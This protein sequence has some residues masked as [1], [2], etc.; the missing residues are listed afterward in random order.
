MGKRVFW[1]AFGAAAGILVVR[2]ASKTLGKLTP[3]ALAEGAAGLPGVF[4][5]AL[6]G[7]ADEVRTAAAERE[8]ELYRALGVDAAESADGHGKHLR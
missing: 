1:I 2:K 8:F 3:S 7:F 4:G 6:Q 5:E